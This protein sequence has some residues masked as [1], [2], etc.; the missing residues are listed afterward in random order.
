MHYVIGDIHNEVRKLNSILEQIQVTQD[1]EIILL[2]DLFDR[3]VE[4]DPAGVYFILSGLQEK[5]TWIRGNHDQW[6]ADYIKKYISLSER[7]RRNMPSYS[8]NSFD[9]LRKRMTEVDM[10]NL[11]DMIQKLPF[12]KDISIEGK[13]YL[14]AHAMTSYPLSWQPNNYYMMGNWD[15]DAFFLEGIDG[16]ISLCGHTPT[17]NILWKTRGTYLDEYKKTIWLNEKENVYLLDC[18][19]GFNDGKLACLCLETGRR[20]YS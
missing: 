3:G 13:N 7:K 10:M 20:F 17:S 5:C 9:L 18:G 1:D 15:L 4:P 2:G 11:A 19:S 14:F 8:Y 12:Q 6:L 16:Y